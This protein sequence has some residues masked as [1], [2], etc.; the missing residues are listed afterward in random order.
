MRHGRLH[1]T[2]GILIARRLRLVAR[3]ESRAPVAALRP[4]GPAPGAACQ[5]W[6]RQLAFALALSALASG[7]SLAFVKPLPPSYGPGDRLDCTTSNAAPDIDMILAALQAGSA[8]VVVENTGPNRADGTYLAIGGVIAGA[9]VS[10]SSAMYG[11]HTTAE[12]RRA[13]AV[14]Q[15]PPTLAPLPIRLHPLPQSEAAAPPTV[16]PARPA[17]Q[18]QDDDGPDVLR[19][20]PQAPGPMGN[21]PSDM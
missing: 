7:C 20:K 1:R 10:L 9:V 16:V 2:D 18:Q 12:C 5:R 11:Y 21:P 15:A 19:P 13:F 6:N 3:A 8:A 14:D 4:A 17:R